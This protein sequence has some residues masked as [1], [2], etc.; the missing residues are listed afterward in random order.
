MRGLQSCSAACAQRKRSAYMHRGASLMH[1]WS[2]AHAA[3]MA[4]VLVSRV[5]CTH[6][7]A[8]HTRLRWRSGVGSLLLARLFCWCCIVVLTPVLCPEAALL[9]CLHCQRGAGGAACMTCMHVMHT[10]MY[11]C[12]CAGQR[13][14]GVQCGRRWHSL[15]CECSVA[16]G[17][18]DC[19]SGRV[20]AQVVCTQQGCED[21]W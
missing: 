19:C 12:A 21:T 20:V 4:V 10:C 1:A 9:A 3:S 11:A 15:R 17:C 6:A 2:D 14:P 7:R 18:F 13:A 16:V 5:G 8:E